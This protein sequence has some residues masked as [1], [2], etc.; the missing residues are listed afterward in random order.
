[1]S[2][3][4]RKAYRFK[5]YSV[6]LARAAKRPAKRIALCVWAGA[7]IALMR[8]PSV[9][10]KEVQVAMPVLHLDLQQCRDMV[11]FNRHT[12]LV[13]VPSIMPETHTEPEELARGDL[14]NEKDSAIY[15]ARERS[16]A[17]LAVS[18]D[19]FLSNATKDAAKPMIV[20]K[21]G[22]LVR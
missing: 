3:P 22:M 18:R 7:T 11:R 13:N 14:Y 21:G 2:T 16:A 1:M 19:R 4:E 8:A 12:E 15:A 9:V 17:Q 6:G 5:V 20:P 10:E